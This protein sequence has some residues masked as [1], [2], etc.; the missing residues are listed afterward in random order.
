MIEVKTLSFRLRLEENNSKNNNCLGNY[1]IVLLG[2][3]A[4]DVNKSFSEE[5]LS[6]SELTPFYTI[7]DAAVFAEEMATFWKM[8]MIINPKLDIT[9]L[10]ELADLWRT[11]SIKLNP[12]LKVYHTN[13]VSYTG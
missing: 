13:K 4:F 12:E 9:R 11:L 2:E 10:E 1:F 8:Q 7:Q 5:F 6:D 3:S